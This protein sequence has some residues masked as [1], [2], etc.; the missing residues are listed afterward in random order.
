MMAFRAD[1]QKA[2]SQL[3]GESDTPV[4]AEL[5]SDGGAAMLVIRKIS[6]SGV[7]RVW[8]WIAS[9]P[10]W[11]IV[12]AP[13]TYRHTM[14]RQG[15]GRRRSVKQ[16]AFWSSDDEQAATVYRIVCR[17]TGRHQRHCE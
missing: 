5:V 2:Q 7:A 6:R 10:L 17:P 15:A 16:M 12:T 11:M 4:R 9:G 3:A 14:I 13:V 8:H 1:Q